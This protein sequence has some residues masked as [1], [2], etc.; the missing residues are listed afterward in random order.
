MHKIQFNFFFVSTK[1]FNSENYFRAMPLSLLHIHDVESVMR[2]F[3]FQ[4]FFLLKKV[5][6]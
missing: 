6:F 3:E 1:A 4:F 5:A 2:M